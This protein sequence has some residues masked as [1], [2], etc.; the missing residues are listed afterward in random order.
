MSSRVTDFRN[1]QVV[2]RADFDLLDDDGRARISMRFEKGP[3]TPEVDELV[4]LLDGRGRGCVGT[5]EEVDGWY[6]YV[7]P[8]PATWVGSAPP[9]RLYSA[10]ARR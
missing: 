6:V 2:L 5:V 9:R 7:R 8:D 1:H 10:S 4:Y 3:G